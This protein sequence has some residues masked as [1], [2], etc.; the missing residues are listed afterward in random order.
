MGIACA[1]LDG[2]G[3]LD[4]FVTNFYRES[5]TFYRNQGDLLFIDATRAARLD[6]P[7]RPFLGFGTQ[8]IDVDLDGRLDLFIANGHIDDFSARG[9]PWKMRPQLFHNAGG[10]TFIDVSRESGDYFT[11][12]YLGRG[13]ARLDWDRDGRADLAVVHQDRPVA[14][15]RNETDQTGNRL[16]LDLHGVESN[17]DAI[18]A[19]IAVTSGGTTRVHEIC[20][21]DGFFASNERRVIS[22]LG[23]ATTIERLE[24]RWPSGRIDEWADL[25]VN[26]ALIVIE[27]RSPIVRIIAAQT[28]DIQ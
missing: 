24:V 14:L 1:D 28:A 16:V 9:E 22:G 21:G 12:E 4:L 2:D 18:G 15:L 13:V 11:G 3:R 5:S 10:A 8:P 19:R 7:T 26:V 23:S 25:P 6:E 17:R 20:G 27:G